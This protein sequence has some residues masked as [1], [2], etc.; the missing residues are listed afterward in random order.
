[1]NLTISNRIK[2]L[3]K[4]LKPDITNIPAIILDLKNNT[5]TYE[6]AL[7]EEAVHLAKEYSISVKEAHKLLK[8]TLIIVDDI[9]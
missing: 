2:Q 3:E 4:K 1:M 8:K 7:A 9:P 6:E 5:K